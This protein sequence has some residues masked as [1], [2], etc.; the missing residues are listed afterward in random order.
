[1]QQTARKWGNTHYIPS[2]ASKE[3]ITARIWTLIDYT[4]LIFGM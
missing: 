4:A 2:L 1:M 3:L